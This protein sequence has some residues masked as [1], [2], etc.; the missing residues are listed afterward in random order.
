MPYIDPT[1]LQ[2]KLVPSSTYHIAP[3]GS[4]IRELV[5]VSGGGL[6]HC[7]MSV[8]KTSCAVAHKTV[9]ELWFFVRGLGQVWRKFEGVESIVDVAAGVSV[10]IPCGTHFQFR[11]IGDEPLKFIIATIPQWPG[12]EEAYTVEGHWKEI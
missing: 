9:E 10:N 4:E 3:D 12:A 11:N 7:V 1:T 5:T 2:T 8:G 6:A